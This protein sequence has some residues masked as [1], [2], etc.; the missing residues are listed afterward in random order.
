MDRGGTTE[1]LI[2]Q[3][4]LTWL[5]SLGYAVLHLPAPPACAGHADRQSNAAR[6]AAVRTSRQGAGIVADKL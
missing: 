6:Q 3:A 4:A 2:E 5:N 1:D